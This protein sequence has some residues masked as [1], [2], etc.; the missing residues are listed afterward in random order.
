MFEFSQRLV[1]GK[2]KLKKAKALGYD[3]D[4]LTMFKEVKASEFLSSGDPIQFLAKAGRLVLD[5][6]RFEQSQYTTEEFRECINDIRVCGGA[7]L[8][9]I[10]NWRKRF[11]EEARQEKQEAE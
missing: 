6:E 11:L 7:E 3:D 1:S 2:G 4:N 9:K 8:R 10:L 5:E